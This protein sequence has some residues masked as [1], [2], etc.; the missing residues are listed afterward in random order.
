M[1]LI[2]IILMLLPTVAEAQRG[3][4][5]PTPVIVYEVGRQ[6]VADK[7][8]A[9]GTLRANESVQITSTVTETITKIHFEDNQLVKKGDVLVEM[10]AREERAEL[11]EER[12][13][14]DE[15]K[16]RVDR[17]RPLVVQGAA[18]EATLD[19]RMRE[20]ETAQAR[21]QAVRSRIN[22]RVIRAPYDGVLGLRNI[23]VGALAQPGTVITTIDDMSVMKLDF[24]VP[25]LYLSALR[26][27]VALTARSNAFPDKMFSGTIAH[28]NSRID[29][30][31]RTIQ[32]RA[33]I[34]NAGGLLRP[35]LLMQ[36]EMQKSQRSSVVIPEESLIPEGQTQSVFVVVEGD[37]GLIAE[38]RPVTIGTR[39][40][41]MVEV[42][43]GIEAGERIVTHGTLRLRPGAAVSIRGMEAEDEPLPELLNQN[44]KTGDTP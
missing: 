17:L 20:M 13:I 30:T 1:R 44:T 22:Q 18:S 32:A 36:V 2:L 40:F 34:D 37:E 29:P 41:G 7:V 5:G 27:G 28:V 33:L 16:R 6:D 11:A 19:Q 14:L 43:E 10:D 42:T 39:S 12:A 8:E 15:A 9:L 4:Q 24:P 38:K 21:V 26:P 25:E 23:S 3:P 35:G 31:T